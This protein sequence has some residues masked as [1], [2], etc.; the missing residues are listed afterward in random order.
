MQSTRIAIAC[1]GGGSHNAFTAG[2]LRELFRTWPKEHQLVALSGSSGGGVCATL[3][4]IGLLQRDMEVSRR[5]LADF[6]QDNSA[7]GLMDSWVN[8][9]L[10]TYAQMMNFLPLPEVSPYRL[11]DW[12]QEQLGSLL[13][14][15]I[16]FAKISELIRDDSPELMIGAV[17]L[18]SGDFHIFQGAKV[19]RQALLASAAIPNLFRAV[20]VEGSLYW[21][22]LFSQNPP[23]HNLT[24]AKPDEIWVIQINPTRR[25]EEP[26]TLEEIRDRRN[27]LAG[28]LSMFQEIR[29][30]TRINELLEEGSLINPAYRPIRVRHIPVE[31]ELNYLSKVDRDPQFLERLMEHG[32]TQAQRFLS[33]QVQECAMANT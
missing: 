8:F 31:L 4:W 32:R 18:L 7:S 24:R 25:R 21:D 30:I 12:G 1:Q 19:T 28:N 14:K 15:H 23:I 27:E 16:P 6:W 26:T 22:G 10:V 29:M 3:S 20:N 9:G 2:V 17:D 13:D 11:P 33:G 5:L